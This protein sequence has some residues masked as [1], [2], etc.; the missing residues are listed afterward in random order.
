[1]QTKLTLRMDEAVI[2]GIKVY[3]EKTNRSVSKIVED[4]FTGITKATTIAPDLYLYPIS[5]DI[6]SMTGIL[7]EG[8]DAKEEYREYLAG[9]HA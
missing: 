6:R 5:D 3:A 7:P 8:I 9:K 1:M 2:A 4:Y